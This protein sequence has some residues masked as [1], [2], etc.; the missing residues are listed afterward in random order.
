MAKEQYIIDLGCD[1]IT[2]CHRGAIIREPAIAMINTAKAQTLLAAGQ[3]VLDYVGEVT[4]YTTFARP[5][6]QGAIKNAKVLELMLGDIL[7]RYIED[8]LLCSISIKVAVP[9][10]LSVADRETLQGIFM[11]LGYKCVELRES[12]LSMQQYVDKKPILVA[13]LGASTSEIGIID[14]NSLITGCT[15]DIGGRNIDKK[16]V[17]LVRYSH[18]VK[19]ED[20]VAE[21][22]KKEIGSLYANC[23]SSIVVRGKDVFLNQKIDIEVSAATISKALTDVFENIAA[24][25]NTVLAEA[26]SA[27]INGIVERGIHII[28]GGAYT[29]GLQEF[30]LKKTGIAAKIDLTRQLELEVVFGMSK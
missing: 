7:S 17:D 2:I 10:G 20:A 5:F 23:D 14:S 1:Y 29:E 19:I 12:L 9:C 25:I 21:S 24:V 3:S 8:K 4:A 13:I 6:R 11:Q 18:N 28:G 30:L 16:I 15:V 26:P 27:A 22:I